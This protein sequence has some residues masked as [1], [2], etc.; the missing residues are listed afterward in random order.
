MSSPPPR[1]E[2]PTLSALPREIKLP[3]LTL[4]AQ[5]AEDAEALHVYASN[6][7]LSVHMSW[8]A[9]TS[10]DDTRAW[11]ANNDALLAGGTA[12][13]WTIEHDG[14]PIGCIGLHGITWAMRALRVDHAE[15]G[16]WLA[17]EHW[18]DGLMTEAAVAITRWG[19]DT[20]GLHKITVRCFEPNEASRRVI[21]KVGFR[22]LCRMEDDVWRDDQW[23]AHL[24]Y[25]LTAPE[26]G[27]T[28]RTLRFK[29]P[30]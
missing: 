30:D 16:Y 27:D 5:R 8:A 25:E 2:I 18:G 10:I 12:I 1:S 14:A 22:F 20:L 23:Y 15:L 21:E 26:F 4:R 3:R 13:V 9:H 6:P 19:F 24:C 7:D 17:P 29:R 11:L 28:T